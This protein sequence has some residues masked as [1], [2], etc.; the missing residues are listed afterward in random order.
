[1]S[2][3][4]TYASSFFAS[5]ISFSTQPYL[6][7]EAKESIVQIVFDSEVFVVQFPYGLRFCRV[8]VVQMGE[9]LGQCRSKLGILF[10]NIPRLL[11]WLTA[12]EI[13]VRILFVTND[14]LGKLSERCIQMLTI[15]ADLA[16]LLIRIADDCFEI[17]VVLFIIGAVLDVEL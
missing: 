10:S 17:A 16:Q 11:H 9:A 13:V 8:A 4:P 7:D 6:I 14:V 15:L 1:M 2:G 5:I 3:F 12:V